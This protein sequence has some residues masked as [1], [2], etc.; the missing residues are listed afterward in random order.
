MPEF[1]FTFIGAESGH[2]PEPEGL[3]SSTLAGSKNTKQAA[4]AMVC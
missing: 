4:N 2:F 1:I 3:A